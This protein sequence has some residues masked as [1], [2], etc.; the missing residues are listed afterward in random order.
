MWTY[1]KDFSQ[2]TS[3]SKKSILKKKRKNFPYNKKEKF[4]WLLFT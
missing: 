1:N 3:I 2:D 4:I